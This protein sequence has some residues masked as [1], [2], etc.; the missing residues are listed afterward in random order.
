MRWYWIDRFIEFESGRL[1]KA[2]KNVTLAEDH[3]HDHFPGYP[4][5]PNCLIIEGMAQTGGLLVCESTGFEEKV[6]WAKIS[7]GRFCGGAAPGAAL[8]SRA[9]ADDIRKGGAVVGATSHKQGQLQAEMS[10][11]FAHLD[12]GYRDK[13]LFERQDM[14]RIMR[15]LRAYDIGRAADGTPLREPVAAEPG[16]EPTGQ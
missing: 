7:G 1:A 14:L 16:T 11:F 9:N 6:V 10:I 2:V 8:T 3:L 12:G 5:M 13:T 15:I 4:V